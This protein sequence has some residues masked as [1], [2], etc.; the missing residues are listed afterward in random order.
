MWTGQLQKK[1]VNPKKVFSFSIWK[2]WYLVAVS[3]GKACGNNGF[4]V[5]K[6]ISG[7]LT[8]TSGNHHHG[9]TLSEKKHHLQKTKLQQKCQVNDTVAVPTLSPVWPEMFEKWTAETMLEKFLLL[10]QKCFMTPYDLNSG[11]VCHTENNV[12]VKF[13]IYRRNGSNFLTEIDGLFFHC[14]VLLWIAFKMQ[15]MTSARMWKATAM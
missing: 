14:R 2:T 11:N 7:F 4:P 10:P 12:S 13:N 5:H 9:W 3:G 8:W 1:N 15:H 6:K